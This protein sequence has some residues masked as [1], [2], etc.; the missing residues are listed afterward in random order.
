C[1][2]DGNV[3]ISISSLTLF[4]FKMVWLQFSLISTLTELLVVYLMN[5]QT[6]SK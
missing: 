1:K 6:K 3:S 2:E 5:K 4:T